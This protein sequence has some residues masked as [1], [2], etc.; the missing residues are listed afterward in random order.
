MARS[1]ITTLRRGVRAAAVSLAMVVTLLGPTAV[2]L[3][4]P[5]PPGIGRPATEEDIR[6]IDFDVR[7]DGQ[8]LPSGGGT[9]AQ[10]RELFAARCAGCHGA[11]GEGTPG[12]PRLVG[13]VPYIVGDTPISTG[14]FWPYAPPIWEYVYRAMPWDAPQ[15]LSQDEVYSLVALILADHGLIGENDRMDARTLPEVRMPNRDA[16]LM[17]D[18]R[19]DIPLP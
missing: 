12:Y 9:A 19:P 5:A 16:Y 2:G 7:P 15:T 11:S 6:A 1:R 8:G 17:V 3:A 4:Q 14:N 10:G 13:P 18:P